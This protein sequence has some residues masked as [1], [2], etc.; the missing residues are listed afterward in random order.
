MCKRPNRRSTWHKV[1]ISLRLLAAS[2]STESESFINR[3]TRKV[4]EKFV[5]NFSSALW[6]SA[7]NLINLSNVHQILVINLHTREEACSCFG[8]KSCQ[9]AKVTVVQFQWHGKKQKENLAE[10][11]YGLYFRLSRY[12]LNDPS[13]WLNGS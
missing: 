1:Q 3:Q 2:K 7:N 5:D 4:D 10:Q 8:T 11:Q 6:Q 13:L 9:D 12:L